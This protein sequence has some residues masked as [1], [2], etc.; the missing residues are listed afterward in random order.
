MNQPISPQQPFRPEAA[1]QVRSGCAKAALFG[2]GGFLLLMR[3]AI[4]V[5]FVKADEITTW[6]LGLLEKLVV[7]R[8]PAATTD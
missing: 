8:L 1:G 7:A 5:F 3:V 2:C 6:G 4:V